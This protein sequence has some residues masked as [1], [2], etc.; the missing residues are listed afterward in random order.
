MCPSLCLPPSCSYELWKKVVTAGA[1][2]NEEWVMCKKLCLASCWRLLV[3]ET[4]K[5]PFLLP[6]QFLC[7]P[8]VWSS[9]LTHLLLPEVPLVLLGLGEQVT[10]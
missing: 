6:C 1:Q 10:E 7:I 9:L 5:K 3:F 2:V 8:K 4:P